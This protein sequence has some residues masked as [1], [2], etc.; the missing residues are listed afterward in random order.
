M[1]VLT[2]DFI[3]FSFNDISSSELGIVRTSN[4][5]R[6]E[7]TLL[8]SFSDNTI[9]VTGSD[10]T[11]YFGS[12][13][14]PKVFNVPI[15]FDSL[16]EEQF[17]RLRTVFGDKEI[18][19]LIFGEAPYKVYDAKI[20]A[21]PQLK[22]ICFNE[23]IAENEKRIYKGEGVLSFVAYYPYAYAKQKAFN[24]YTEENK[25][26]WKITSGLKETLDGYDIYDE[27]LGK[28]K[29]YNPGDIESDFYLYF[30]FNT[31]E[32]TIA[33]SDNSRTLSFDKI[34]KAPDD[35]SNRLRIN[36]KLH[37][38][39]SL[40]SNNKPSGFVYNKYITKGDFF[41]IP[42]GEEE[43]QITSTETL[44]DVEIDYKYWYY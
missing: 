12:N 14:S 29:V 8:P 35:N 16:T 21:P 39:E 15:A 7:E 44:T 25:N 28:I 11:H 10:R 4:G 37:L 27:T 38:I 34:E 1:G 36:T 9:Q 33:L 43:I 30:N 26:E 40:D 20:S 13:Y 24:E 6:Y 18:H 41:K 32:I 23:G 3:G 2:G 31:E 5:S 42:I 19:S 22:Y 17:R